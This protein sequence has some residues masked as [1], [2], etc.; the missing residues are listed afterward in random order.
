M[1]SSFSGI[2]IDNFLSQPAARSA[3][4]RHSLRF[5]EEISDTNFDTLETIA[6]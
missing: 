1:S 3:P 5:S 4:V 2:P 6:E